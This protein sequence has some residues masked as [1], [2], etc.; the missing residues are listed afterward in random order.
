VTKINKTATPLSDKKAMLAFLKTGARISKSS[1]E[2][3]IN[4]NEG[5]RLLTVSISDL[6]GLAAVG[7]VIRNA[8][9]VVLTPAGQ[10]IA[11]QL[12]QRSDIELHELPEKLDHAPT[13]VLANLEESPLASLQRGARSG[14]KAFLSRMEFE[15]GER[16]RSDFTRAMLMPRI[17]ANWT[18]SVSA[19]RRAGENNGVE[20]LTNSA[21]SAKLRFEAALAGLGQDLSGAVADICCF[22]KGFEQVEM[23]RKWPKRSAKFMLKAGLAV[24]ALHYW[25]KSAQTQKMRQWGA[26]DYRP[27]INS[28]G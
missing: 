6:S 9:Q 28:A 25:P 26:P 22:L 4:L 10:E 16:I 7:L 17:S 18:A 27:E 21:L 24:L 5:G 15:A 8:G 13:I 3:H 14:G 2:G 20:S 19:G 12:Q 23:E 1:T 11:A